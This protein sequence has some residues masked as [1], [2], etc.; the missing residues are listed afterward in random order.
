MKGDCGGVVAGGGG[1]G[2]RMVREN[3][4]GGFEE[5]D[6]IRFSLKGV[7]PIDYLKRVKGC[8]DG[9]GAERSKW[10]R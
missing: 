5:K 8:L 2:R 6:L 7:R 3:W 4:R 10:W 1:G 9:F